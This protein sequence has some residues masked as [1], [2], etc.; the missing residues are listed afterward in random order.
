[1]KVFCP[2]QFHLPVAWLHSASSEWSLSA[3]LEEPQDP[4]CWGQLDL[5]SLY[6]NLLLSHCL[7][8]IGL[9]C[10]NH[11]TCRLLLYCLRPDN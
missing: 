3:Q 9:L 10:R 8:F 11:L 4:V 1:M 5:Q 7:A 2:C 6:I